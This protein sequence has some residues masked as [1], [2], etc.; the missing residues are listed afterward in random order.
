MTR[1]DG[2]QDNELR[3][4][5]LESA[6]LSRA[7]GSAKFSCGPVSVLASVS[8][9][10]E[11]RLRDELVDRAAL[12]INM[13]PV[14]GLPG[15]PTKALVD[16]LAS[17]FT[18]VLLLNRHPRSLIQLSLQTISLPSTRYSKAFRTFQE[19]PLRSDDD[20]ER[21]V[22]EDLASPDSQAESVAE[23]AASIN[24]AT[25]S[26]L[27][28]AIGM[29]AVVCAVAI[30]MTRQ[31][32]PTAEAT[33]SDD[34]APRHRI[35]LDPTAEEE[36]EAQATLCIAFA[37]GLEIGGPEGDV[38][39]FDMTKGSLEDEQLNQTIEVARLACSS[40]LNFIRK[41]QETRYLGQ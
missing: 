12:E 29:K 7:D 39:Y 37:Y 9:P 31:E 40:V 27:D 41:T 24:A 18:P 19:D 2:R 15:P 30:A 22:D 17:V 33:S 20:E 28:A 1:R 13:R 10:M 26:L 36:R 5:A 6:L 35:L 16:S 14:R 8:G 21:I 23:K 32:S 3:Q 11:V 34:N 38:C 25:C 4:L